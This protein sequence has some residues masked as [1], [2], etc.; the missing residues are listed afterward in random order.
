MSASM[1]T[2]PGLSSRA[3]CPIVRP[4]RRGLSPAAGFSVDSGAWRSTTVVFFSPVWIAPVASRIAPIATAIAPPARPER[5]L[6]LM[7]RQ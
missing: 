5:K 7:S 1:K 2:T 6:D 3:I 4:P